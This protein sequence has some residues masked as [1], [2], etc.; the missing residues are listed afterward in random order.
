MERIKDYLLEEEFIQNQEHLKNEETREEKNDSEVMN[1][2]ILHKSASVL[3][4]T[5]NSI[6]YPNT[7]LIFPIHV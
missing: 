5:R 6:P 7:C 2:I 4:L 3:L 1:L